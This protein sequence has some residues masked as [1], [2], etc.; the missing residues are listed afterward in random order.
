MFKTAGALRQ[1]RSTPVNRKD[2]SSRVT[3]VLVALATSLEEYVGVLSFLEQAFSGASKYQLR[4]RP[5]PAFSLEAALAIAPLA[6][7][8]FYSESTGPL[9][10]DLE[11]AD[12][13]LY[14]SST[15]GMEAISAG[16]PAVNLDLGDFLNRDPLSGWIDF[17]WTAKLPSELPGI[18]ESVLDM[19][20]DEFGA[21]QEKGRR[22]IATYLS[23]VAAENLGCFIDC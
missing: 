15:V 22:Y 6:G 16:I 7:P 11:W 8:K 2:R 20:Q 14:A 17:R 18:I 1:T 12:V 19:P 9:T 5:H 23:P 13:V 4:I 3:Q 10:E 21:R